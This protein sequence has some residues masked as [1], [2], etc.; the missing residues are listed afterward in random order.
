VSL[1][2]RHEQLLIKLFKKRVWNPQPTGTP[3]GKGPQ[4]HLPF[5]LKNLYAF[6]FG[7]EPPQNN[8]SVRNIT[9]CWWNNQKL[10]CGMALVI[11]HPLSPSQWYLDWLQLLGY[12]TSKQQAYRDHFMIINQMLLFPNSNEI[13]LSGPQ[14]T[15][16]ISG[17]KVVC[18]RC[19][20]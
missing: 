10:H 9:G 5:H 8:N 6:H 7:Q 15:T 19:K 17:D 4:S 2:V 11:S 18:D 13:T 16:S 20:Y 3:I 14:F 12:E 1:L